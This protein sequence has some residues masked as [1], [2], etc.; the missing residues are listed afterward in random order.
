M[1]R[2]IIFDFGGVLTKNKFFE[3]SS[4]NIGKLSSMNDVEILN[5]MKSESQKYFTG[6]EDGKEYWNRVCSKIGID[7][8]E[9]SF[10][11]LLDSYDLDRDSLRLASDMRKKY[12]VILLSDNF[13]ELADE[14]KPKIGKYFDIMYFSNEIHATKSSSSAFE[15]MLEKSRLSAEECVFIDDKEENTEL[16]K[17]LGFFV[18]LYSDPVQAR[19]E[20]DRILRE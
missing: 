14:L 11:I 2:A 10:R 9:E 8:N 17:S 13:K 18:I 5:I 1:I 6:E 7:P 12:T 19:K 15:I 3:S 4:K 20:L 16:A